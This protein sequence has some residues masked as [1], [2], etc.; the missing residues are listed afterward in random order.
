MT[1]DKHAYSK[2]DTEFLDEVKAISQRYP[3]AMGRYALANLAVE[4]DMGIDRDRRVGIT[5]VENGQVITRF[6]DRDDPVLARMRLCLLRDI[7]GNCLD[8]MEAPE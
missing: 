8:W 1:T 2:E 5:R 6:V 4:R 3:E 7:H